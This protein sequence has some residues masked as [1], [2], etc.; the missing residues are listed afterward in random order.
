[1]RI[2][3]NCRLRKCLDDLLAEDESGLMGTFVL[4]AV[5]D[6]ASACVKADPQQITKD[7]GGWVNGHAWVECARTALAALEQLKSRPKPLKVVS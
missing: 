2:P 5:E 4:K 6:F 3:R 1:M 7:A